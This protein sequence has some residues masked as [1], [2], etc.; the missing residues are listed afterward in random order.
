M[1]S[2]HWGEMARGS[3][4]RVLLFV[5]RSAEWVAWWRASCC[6]AW[7]LDALLGMSNEACSPQTHAIQWVEKVMSRREVEM[8]KAMWLMETREDQRLAKREART[9]RM[10]LRRRNAPATR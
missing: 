5:A 2:V 6:G 3:V 7:C 1:A 9:R 4:A 8:S 10:S